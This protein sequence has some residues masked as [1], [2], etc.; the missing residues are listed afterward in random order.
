MVSRIS[1]QNQ[2][3]NTI[4]LV[5]GCASA[6]NAE[7]YKSMDS[8][9][10]V[11]PKAQVEKELLRICNKESFDNNKEI[12]LLASDSFR[13]RAALKIQD[14]CNNACTYCIVH[15]ARGPA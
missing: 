1:K 6:I 4:I 13:T 15:T 10:L 3:S 8:R 12:E 11:V 9:I 5:T 14:G 2:K 7:I